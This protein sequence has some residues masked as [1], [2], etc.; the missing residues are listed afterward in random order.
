MM[1]MLEAAFDS[2]W[3]Q[4]CALLH[5]Y[6]WAG[7]LIYKFLCVIILSSLPFTLSPHPNT[8]KY[9]ERERHRLLGRQA[10]EPTCGTCQHPTKPISYL[11]L[12]LGDCLCDDP[13]ESREGREGIKSNLAPVTSSILQVISVYAWK[14]DVKHMWDRMRTCVLN[15]CTLLR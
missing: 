10:A 8:H 4:P 13:K 7:S 15:S 9:T 6:I 12:L 14:S 5:L 1:N 3:M 2:H 11:L